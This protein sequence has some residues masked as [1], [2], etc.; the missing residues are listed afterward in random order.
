MA[1]FTAVGRIVTAYRPILIRDTSS[2]QNLLSQKTI[3][4]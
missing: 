3:R 2:Y 4:D 1:V